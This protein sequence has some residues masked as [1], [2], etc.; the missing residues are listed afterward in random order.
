VLTQKAELGMLDPGW[1]P[2]PEGWDDAGLEDAEAV[3]G[4][5][6]LDTDEDRALARSVA[7]RAVTLVGNDGVLPLPADRPLRIAVV[8]PLADDPFAMLGCY[9]FPRHVGLLHPWVPIGIELPTV[10]G[11]LRTEFP[12]ATI[13]WDDG[14]SVD[15]TGDYEHEGISRAVA[16]AREADVTIAVL[17]DRAGLFGRG[18]SGEGCDAASMRL[19]GRQQNLLDA[20]IDTGTPV[21]VTLI[22]GRP[23]AIGSAADRAAA[24][25]A[26]FFPGEEGGPA[27]AGVLSGRVNP[28]GRLPIG[29]P[30][31]EGGQPSGY[32]AAPLAAKTP[33]SS[34]DPTARFPFGHGLS[35]T[36]FEWSSPAID[37]E[38]IPTDGA[39]RVSVEVTN[40]GERDGIENVQLY[41][42]DPVASVVRPVNRLVGYAS[43]PLPAGSGCR[44]S[45]DVHADLSSF[46]G[47]DGERVVEPGE[48]ELRFGASSGDIR[49]ALPVTLTGDR[50]VVDHTRV[51]TAPVTLET[52]PAA[53]STTP[54]A[55]RP[56]ARRASSPGRP[57]R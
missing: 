33:V 26:S 15:G 21:V 31:G 6:R 8:G 24:I 23:Y 34:V 37:S 48:L 32:L 53:A 46:T 4:S 25:V 1:S 52:P 39:V 57:R 45:F 56:G 30:A 43:V 7:E 49:F 36:T 42:H 40:A 35:Y 12:N 28:S 13:T 11:S 9:S 41:L 16:A 14:V 55:P 3:R 47:R 38:R 2:V 18:T 27:I 51:L 29:M 20:L 50:R 22:E 44:V 54:R 5:V 17:G 10:L 19:P